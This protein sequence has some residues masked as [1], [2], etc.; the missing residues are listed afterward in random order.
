MPWYSE[1]PPWF[2]SQFFEVPESRKV[3]Y[4]CQSWGWERSDVLFRRPLGK[5]TF[6]LPRLGKVSHLSTTVGAGHEPRT[7]RRPQAYFDEVPPSG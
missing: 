6:I 5:W 7:L 4:E 2:L 1:K 3:I